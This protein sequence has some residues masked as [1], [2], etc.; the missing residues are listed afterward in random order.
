MLHRNAEDGFHVQSV[1]V[2][3]CEIFDLALRT[4]DPKS[5]LEEVGLR[6][7]H[8][9]FSYHLSRFPSALML[10]KETFERHLTAEGCRILPL[11][12]AG[13]A[14]TA[15]DCSDQ[16]W[17]FFTSPATP[18]GRKLDVALQRFNER[19]NEKPRQRKME[20][21]NHRGKQQSFQPRG[22]V[23]RKVGI[24][25][26]FEGSSSRFTKVVEVMPGA[27]LPQSMAFP[28]VLPGFQIKWKFD[29]RYGENHGMVSMQ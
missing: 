3:I 1:L 11:T 18:D 29:P 22:G 17:N 14:D 21:P 2:R 6:A 8:V 27:I 26:R 19:C 10:P 7:E 4:T 20:A 25:C 15:G 13:S 5:S 16:S 12:A 23:S 24:L 9:Q 28:D